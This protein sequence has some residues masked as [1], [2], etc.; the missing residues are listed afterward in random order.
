M[1]GIIPS[2]RMLD[3]K[4]NEKISKTS[5]K[6]GHFKDRVILNRNIKLTNNIKVYQSMV[7]NTLLSS[8]EASL[9]YSKQ[10]KFLKNQSG[11]SQQIT[12]HCVVRQSVK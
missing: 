9:I 2:N 10:L 7:A 12:E 1:I 3:R 11:L 5:T 8:C 6:F 4:F